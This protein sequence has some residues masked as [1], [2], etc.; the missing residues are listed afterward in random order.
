MQLELLLQFQPNEEV[1]LVSYQGVTEFF[2]DRPLELN[3]LN[4][5]IFELVGNGHITSR[6]FAEKLLENSK[7]LV[8]K[9]P[10]NQVGT[11]HDTISHLQHFLGDLP[12]ALVSAKLAAAAPDASPDFQA[13]VT[14]IEEELAE[15]QGPK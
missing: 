14:K 4:W 8:E 10:A 9:V 5:G 3:G 6:K 11:V 2:V 7:P 13:F 15:K 1:T 12:S